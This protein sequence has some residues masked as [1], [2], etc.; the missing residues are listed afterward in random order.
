MLTTAMALKWDRVKQKAVSSD[1][2]G[3]VTVEFE[4]PAGK[5]RAYSSELGESA[6]FVEISQRALV[7]VDESGKELGDAWNLEQGFEWD[8]FQEAGTGSWVASFG[9]VQFP[10]VPGSTFQDGARQFALTVTATEGSTKK[11]D[12]FLSCPNCVGDDDVGMGSRGGCSDI[13]DSD[14]GNE[15]CSSRDL[16][17]T[18]AGRFGT[19]YCCASY[20]VEAGWY[21]VDCPEGGATTS[22]QE[23]SSSYGDAVVDCSCVIATEITDPNSALFAGTCQQPEPG[24]N[25]HPC[26][27]ETAVPAYSTNFDLQFAAWDFASPG[28]RLQY[29]ARIRSKMGG[30]ESKKGASQKNAATGKWETPIELDGGAFYIA[31]EG[32]LM[33]GG[34]THKCDISNPKTETAS[35]L[36]ITCDGFDS[37]T[38]YL[39][40][41]TRLQLNDPV[42]PASAGTTAP[43]V[44]TLLMLYALF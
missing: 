41:A 35:Y 40:L 16:A 6:G 34:E 28:N 32:T 27:T 4:G 17:K 2:F 26:F 38:H 20:S 15:K 43:L 3:E 9:A 19:L 21:K 14:L 1:I 23:P 42:W 30:K 5:I 24:V 12:Y 18:R 10:T 37:S 22:C 25:Y 7:E 39:Q 31:S 8:A 11:T 44:A 13:T 33:P 36:Y 29:R